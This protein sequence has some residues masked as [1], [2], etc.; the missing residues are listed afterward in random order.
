MNND[1]KE[2]KPQSSS[3]S[4]SNQHANSIQ[5][6]QQ[7]IP[8]LKASQTPIVKKDSQLFS[9]INLKDI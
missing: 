7:K 3:V 2:F 5:L 6:R 8:A 9:K 1:L 4:P